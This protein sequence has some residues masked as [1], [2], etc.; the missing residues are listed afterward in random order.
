MR[1]VLIKVKIANT[2]AA[3]GKK[4]IGL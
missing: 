2:K 3:E 4:T 1:W